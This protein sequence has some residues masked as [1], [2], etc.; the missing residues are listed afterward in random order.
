MSN[1]P[2]ISVLLPV[3]NGG[4][5]LEDAIESI[6]NQTFTNFEFII[7]DD[8]S[9]DSSLQVIQKYEKRDSRIRL[10]TRENRGLVSTLNELVDMASGV[11]VARMDSDDIALP[12]RFERQMAWLEKTGAD[13][14]GSW[15]RRFGTT[16]QRIVRKH[17]S[18]AAIK[19]E[20]LFGSP[21][22]H[23]SV[24]I[25]SSLIKKFPF[26]ATWVKAED[27]DLWIRAAE[28]GWKMTNVPEVLLHYR[29]H[30]AQ[31]STS[32]AELQ[33][34]Q[35]QKLRRGY[36]YFVFNSMNL[37]NKSIDDTLKI[38]NIPLFEIDMNAVEASFLALLR[39]SQDESRDI[40]FSHATRLY[41]RAAASCRDIVSRWGNL[42][43]ELGRGAGGTTKMKLA[44]FRLFRIREGTFLFRCFKMLYYWGIVR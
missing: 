5:Y 41:Y 4:A 27:Y 30:S 38:F 18:D 7:I 17:Q 24:I 21:F 15:V 43:Q 10:V 26:D 9:T 13:V 31:V 29:V 20:L 36:W 16:D 12:A 14:C 19:T 2:V 39:H 42:N 32:A 40:I 11:W 22:V 37:D 44:L 23:P 34:L 3:Y 33:Q 8:G 1:L 35:G 6:L 25:R 28:A